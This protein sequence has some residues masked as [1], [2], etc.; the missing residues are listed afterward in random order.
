MAEYIFTAFPTPDIMR[1][2]PEFE[3]FYKNFQDALS[4]F[5]KHC[6]LRLCDIWVRDF[7]PLQ[8]IENNSLHTMFYDPTHKRAQYKNIYAQI[9]AEVNKLF[10]AAAP[11]NIRMDGGNITYNRRGVALAFEKASIRKG[12]TYT[13]ISLRLKESLNLEEIIWLP[14]PHDKYDPFVHIDGFMQF[15]GDD[16][17]LTNKPCDSRSAKHLSKCKQIIKAKFPQFKIVELPLWSSPDDNFGAKGIYVNFLETS[18]A[19][20]VAQYNLAEDGEALAIIKQNTLK[21]VIGVDCEGISKHGGSL[22]C[23]T[24]VLYYSEE[25]SVNEIYRRCS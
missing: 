11:L 22:H 23:L 5:H 21:P 17:L 18:R 20:F 3:A 8:N 1:L 25:R 6:P 16:I 13:D 14:N 15:L 19:I 12:T 10:P 4:Q 9:R 7:L 2:Y 24:Q